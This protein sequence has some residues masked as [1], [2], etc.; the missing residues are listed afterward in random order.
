MKEKLLEKGYKIWS[1]NDGGERI[2]INNIIKYLKVQKTENSVKDEIDIYEDTIEDVE[3]FK[4]NKPKA[5]DIV[6]GLTSGSA[7]L[8]YDVEKDKFHWYSNYEELDKLI[9]IAIKKIRSL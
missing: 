8:Y 3:L 1:K 6:A 4:I 5:R 7:K 2:Y 9:K